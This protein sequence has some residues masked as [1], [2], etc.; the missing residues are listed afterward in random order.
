MLRIVFLY[1]LLLNVIY[2]ARPMITDDG[3]V[4]ESGACQ[5]ETWGI[6]A[7]DSNE[8]WALPAC[9]F[10][11][12]IE[13]SMGG[14]FGDD[15]VDRYLREW[16]SR[17]FL[18]GLKKIFG[19]LDS[20]ESSYFSYG[21]AIG[22]AYNFKRAS[23]RNDH[24]AY[25][26]ASKALFDSRLILHTNI[27][28]KLLRNTIEHHAYNAGFGFEWIIVPRFSLIGE[29]FAERFEKLKY[30]AG[31]RIWLVPN[32]LQLDS[33]YGNAFRGQDY[34]VSLGVRIISGVFW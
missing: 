23:G 32:H 16:G 30:Q 7:K 15:A 24:Y 10:S 34:F 29:S 9:G 13:I 6:W 1:F 17:Q 3:A 19:D 12:N 14:A 31:F 28:Y 11:H 18:F 22:N 20:A 26:I 4:T 25:L 8:Y 27:G 33:T 21:I 2:A 5:L